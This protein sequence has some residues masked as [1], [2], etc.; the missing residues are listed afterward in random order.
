MPIIGLNLS[1]TLT[2]ACGLCEHPLVSICHI[3]PFSEILTKSYL[4][5]E[6]PII[7]QKTTFE[8]SFI[9]EINFFLDY[10]AIYKI[11][12]RPSRKIFFLA[13]NRFSQIKFSI[14]GVKLNLRIIIITEKI[15]SQF[16]STVSQKKR[17]LRSLVSA[18]TTR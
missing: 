2:V 11:G 1:F 8:L 3:Q 5:K 10:S 13:K 7:E 12:H 9:A 6:G 15:C 16:R 4:F 14:I 17:I 18:E